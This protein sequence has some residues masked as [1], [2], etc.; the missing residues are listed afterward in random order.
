MQR[1]REKR[2]E[3]RAGTGPV[4]P[5]DVLTREYATQCRAKDALQTL[6]EYETHIIATLVL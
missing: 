5:Q 3:R 4:P 6:V 1:V 2:G